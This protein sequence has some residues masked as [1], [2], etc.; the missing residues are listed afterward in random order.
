MHANLA[1]PVITIENH[2]FTRLLQKAPLGV[3][4]EYWQSHL[5]ARPSCSAVFLKKHGQELSQTREVFTKWRLL[6]EPGKPVVLDG[7]DWLGKVGMDEANAQITFLR[8]YV[9]NGPAAI[10]PG[11]RQAK[12]KREPDEAEALDG[13]GDAD[14]H[15]NDKGDEDLNAELDA[16]MRCSKAWKIRMA[17]AALSRNSL[18]SVPKQ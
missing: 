14:E 10:A 18:K 4:N 13:N 15:W 6:A 9:V 12:R 2:R 8:K 1:K 17:N 11:S 7:Y 5:A 3:R 16:E